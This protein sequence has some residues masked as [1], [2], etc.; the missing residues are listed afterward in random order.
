MD[1]NCKK[2]S[3]NKEFVEMTR[4]L[5]TASN[6]DI[7]IALFDN[8][9]KINKLRGTRLKIAALQQSELIAELALRN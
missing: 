6:D 8:A 7:R 2:L 5:L 3:T 9:G 1:I 4:P